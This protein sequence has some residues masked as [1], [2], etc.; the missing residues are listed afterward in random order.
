MGRRIKRI[1]GTVASVIGT[2]IAIDIIGSL[3][4]MILAAMAG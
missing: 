2:L 4:M 1:L 3:I